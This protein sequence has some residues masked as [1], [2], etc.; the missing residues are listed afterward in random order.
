[1]G[2]P[3]LLVVKLA[4]EEWRHWL[5]GAEHPFVVWTDHKNLAYIQN[6]KRLNSHQ[7]HWQ[8][9]FTRFN[10]T[11]TYRPGKHDIKPNALSHQYTSHDSSAE[12]ET[13][14]STSC[15]VGAVTRE[16]ESKIREAQHTEPDPGN[17]PANHQY[18]P[19]SF[20]SHVLQWTHASC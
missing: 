2:N 16:M 1:M 6:A 20:H 14:L 13:I 15:V 17:G 4:L 11:L 8:L 10:F 19:T 12:P 5:E 18:V 9:F 3:E 7:A